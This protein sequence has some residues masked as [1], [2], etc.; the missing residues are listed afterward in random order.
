M[1]DRAEIIIRQVALHWGIPA[2]RL[3]SKG[4]TKHLQLAKADCRRRLRY[5]AELSWREINDLLG[6]SAHYHRL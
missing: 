2:S 3:T 4:R 5:E 6:Y 1:Y